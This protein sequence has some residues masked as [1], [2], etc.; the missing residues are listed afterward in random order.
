MEQ[1]LDTHM[2]EPSRYETKLRHR[3]VG[4]KTTCMHGC[5][6]HIGMIG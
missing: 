6:R 1:S 4:L 5:V 3:Q 2:D